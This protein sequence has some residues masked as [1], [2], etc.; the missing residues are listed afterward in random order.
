MSQPIQPDLR[1]EAQAQ[2]PELRPA[3]LA[4]KVAREQVYQQGPSGPVAVPAAVDFE[5][6]AVLR[7]AQ[8]AADASATQLTAEEIAEFRQ[9]RREK[10]ER[11]EDAAKE[12][13]AAAARLTPPTHW[14]HLAD[15]SVIDGHQIAT[16]YD[17]GGRVT[18]VAA[19][20]EKEP[21]LL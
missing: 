5:A 7:D 13:A 3:G 4:A 16:H 12:A 8:A 17:E 21:V 11:D 6:Q 19:V 10:R 15:G 20:F 2:Y 18:P 14:V 9:L 1:A